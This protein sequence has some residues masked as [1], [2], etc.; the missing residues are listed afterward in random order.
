MARPKTKRSTHAERLEEI[1]ALA[2]L[3]HEVISET[4]PEKLSTSWDAVPWSQVSA[5]C[6]MAATTL[7]N[8]WGYTRDGR[9]TQYVRA[10]TL[11][12]LAESA[13]LGQ[14]FYNMVTVARKDKETALRVVRAAG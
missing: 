13:G 4:L 7:K 14:L 8:I 9:R 3:C 6:G 11:Q 1:Y 10:D 5:H 2:D 12:K